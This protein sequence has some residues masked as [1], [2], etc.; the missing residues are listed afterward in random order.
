MFDAQ[1]FSKYI[2]SCID[3]M[4]DNFEV[5]GE[6]TV[7]VHLLSGDVLTVNTVLPQAGPDIVALGCVFQN[8]KGDTT[9]RMTTVC[10]PV[11]NISRVDLVTHADNPSVTGKQ[12]KFKGYI[13]RRSLGEPPA[14]DA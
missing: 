4:R 8:K 6:V 2:P 3:A 10:V 9:T 7:I 13:A 14:P 5:A 1:F 11:K 12:R